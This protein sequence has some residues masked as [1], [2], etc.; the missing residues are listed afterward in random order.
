MG[1][2][3]GHLVSLWTKKTQDSFSIDVQILE[4][5]YPS[6]KKKMAEVSIFGCSQTFK[7]SPLSA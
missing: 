2:T 4:I 1:V 5:H 7:R 3:G 6:V